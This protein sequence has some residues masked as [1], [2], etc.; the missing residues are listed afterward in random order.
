[1]RVSHFSMAMRVDMHERGMLKSDDRDN[2]K[3]SMTMEILQM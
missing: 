1:M 2:V 3:H